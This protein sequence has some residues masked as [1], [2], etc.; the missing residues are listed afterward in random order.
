MNKF[1]L[2]FLKIYLSSYIT[3]S[4]TAILTYCRNI[5]ACVYYVWWLFQQDKI[6]PRIC[7]C[8]VILVYMEME[9][10]FRCDNKVI[11][12]TIVI[13][14]TPLCIAI[15]A[16]RAFPSELGKVFSEPAGKARE[17]AVVCIVHC[18]FTIFTYIQRKCFP[19]FQCNCVFMLGLIWLVRENQ[20]N[21]NII[22]LAFSLDVHVCNKLCFILKPVYLF[23]CVQQGCLTE[24]FFWNEQQIFLKIQLERYKRSYMYYITWILLKWNELLFKFKFDATSM[25]VTKVVINYHT[26]YI[27]NLSTMQY[28][29]ETILE[30]SLDLIMV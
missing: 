29:E 22:V 24:L 30:I 28:L 14:E 25:D 13:K 7:I 16:S 27:T 5:G 1:S 9:I 20:K 26:L 8:Y 18:M 15:A 4:I 2:N 17:T 21:E 10:Q 23:F 19:W 12:V 3:F 11:F 6:T